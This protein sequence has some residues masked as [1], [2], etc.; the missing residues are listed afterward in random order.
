M[1]KIPQVNLI[2]SED[3]Y[4]VEILGRTQL[5]YREGEKSILIDAEGLAE[6]AFLIYQD[7]ITRWLP[8]HDREIIS[9]AA[10]EK[11]IER[12]RSA[13]QFYGVEVQII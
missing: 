9:D 4:S 5:L 11:I 8:P 7:S 10:R 1:F 12:V 13:L 3:G 2:E 6:P